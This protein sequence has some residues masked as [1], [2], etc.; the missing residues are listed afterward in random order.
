AGPHG[1]ARIE[2]RVADGR[3]RIT[4]SDTG[5][6]I[7]VEDLPHIFERFYRGKNSRGTTGTGLGLA[8][9][10]WVAEQHGGE[11]EVDTAPGQGSRFTVVLP[12]FI[13]NS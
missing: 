3:A 7:E 1:E 13:L 5:A 12:V 2:S 10:R 11:L 6:G 9:A 8:I 4:V